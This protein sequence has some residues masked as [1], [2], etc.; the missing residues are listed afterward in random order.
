MTGRR[1][2]RVIATAHWRERVRERIG[3]S[4]CPERLAAALF[5]AIDAGDCARVAYL[6]R[7]RRDGTRAFCFALG[8]RAFVALVEAQ[9]R[10]AI[11]VLGAGQSVRLSRGELIDCAAPRRASAAPLVPLCVAGEGLS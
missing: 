9:R 6:G 8:G 5:R 1:L 3:P 7:V 11:T 4:I 2:G 10:S